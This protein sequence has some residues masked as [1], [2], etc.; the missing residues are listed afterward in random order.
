MHV[1]QTMQCNNTSINFVFGYSKFSWSSVSFLL[2]IGKATVVATAKFLISSLEMDTTQCQSKC[3]LCYKAAK[4]GKIT[5]NIWFMFAKLNLRN[6][7]I[8]GAL[9]S[10]TLLSYS[11]LYHFNFACYGSTYLIWHSLQNQSTP[12]VLYKDN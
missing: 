11:W 2:R 5:C 10:S 1:M 8:F 9:R 7:Q 3:S 4:Q 12:W 6:M